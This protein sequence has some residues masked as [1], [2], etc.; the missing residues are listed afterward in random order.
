MESQS[1]ESRRRSKDESGNR[2]V[3]TNVSEI[4]EM[5]GLTPPKDAMFT[6]LFSKAA[7]GNLP[8]YF[9]AVPRSLVRPF[10]AEYDPRR[11]PIGR[12]A[13][14]A[15]KKD[16]L[17]GKSSNM[18]VYPDGSTYVMSDDYI[19][20]FAAEEGQPD[21]L[22]C[23]ILGETEDSRIKD[24]QGPIQVSDVRKAFGVTD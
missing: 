24:I 4:H 21:F 5:P 14:D 18:W 15:K 6:Y 23:F 12:Q 7:E 1:D 17:A 20:F 16:W 10:F 19:T 13:V 22:P 11:H 9:A 2:I 3:T 8:V